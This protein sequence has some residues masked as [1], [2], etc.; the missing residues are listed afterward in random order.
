MLKTPRAFR[1]P[2]APLG[3]QSVTYLPFWMMGRQYSALL[4]KTSPLSTS[5]A[6]TWRFRSTVRSARFLPRPQSGATISTVSQGPVP[7]LA[8]NGES[9][10]PAIPAISPRFALSPRAPPTS[11]RGTSEEKGISRKAY[12]CGRAAGILG[13]RLVGGGPRPSMFAGS[14]IM[15]TGTRSQCASCLS[16]PRSPSPNPSSLLL[17]PQARI[18]GRVSLKKSG[19]TTTRCKCPKCQNER[20]TFPV[21]GSTVESRDG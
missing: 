20:H 18:A 21:C 1:P 16:L 2:V 12:A 11:I 19:R 14:R 4:P 15:T 3:P 5:T 8:S 10:R 9:P 17:T 13:M 7:S 6:R